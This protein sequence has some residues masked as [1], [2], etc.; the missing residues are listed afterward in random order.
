MK[1]VRNKLVVKFDVSHNKS[2]GKGLNGL[3]IIRPDMWFDKELED[4]TSQFM[5]NENKLL[6]H[7]QIVVVAIGNEKYKAGDVLFVHYMA[8][9][10]EE[11]IA[12]D[13]EEHSII[14]SGYVIFKMT[15]DGYELVDDSFLGDRVIENELVL[16]SGLIL[17]VMERPIASR[18]R[19][20]HLPKER[21]LET[22]E[23]KIGDVVLTVDDNQYEMNIGGGQ[24]K[25]KLTSEEIYAIIE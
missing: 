7:P 17:N 1:T 2:V 5:S 6:V 4:G 10:W 20:T 24:K 16:S 25:V 22:S 11:K 13:G 23:I 3:D 8:K 9:E 18:I 21:C 12:L 19:I 14:D 15:D